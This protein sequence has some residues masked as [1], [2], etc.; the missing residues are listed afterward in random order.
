[1]HIIDPLNDPR[2]A[3]FVERHPGA[4]AF[5]TER[6]LRAL[7]QTYGYEPLAITS[8]APG[9]ALTDAVP[10]CRIK[11]WA[12][13]RRLVSLPFSDH[14]QPL[15]GSDAGG[16]DVIRF[17]AEYSRRE[18]D[19]FVEFRPAVPLR[20][21]SLDPEHEFTCYYI[22]WLDLTPTQERIFN[23]FHKDSI[24]RKIR[25]AEREGLRYEEGRSQEIIAKFY[26][27]LM[28]TRRR[29]Q[30]PPQPIKWFENLAQSMGESIQYRI[31]IKD[32][33][34]VAAIVTLI[35]RNSMIYKYGCSDERFH[36][37]GGTPFLFW[38]MIQDAKS[39][40]VPLL[41]LGRTDIDNAGLIRFKDE[42]GT[43]RTELRY[44]RYPAPAAS[45]TS[46]GIAARVAKKI[47]ANM[48]DVLLEITG[49]LI[50]RH[51]G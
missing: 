4:C 42:W 36:A 37:A 13:G 51:I 19:G 39:A 9:S 6:W 21:A 33:V 44:Y 49:K 47:F 8:S 23:S 28:R 24:Q 5:H 12:T 3:P 50:Y 16:G 46:D 11:S 20:D 41:D 48:P 38:R 34:P 26:S 10:F 1:M 22:H 31:S 29:H 45:K 30:L 14:C 43:R 40:G 35:H 2:W 7:A 15:L 25:R 18:G 32:N 17:A 27:L